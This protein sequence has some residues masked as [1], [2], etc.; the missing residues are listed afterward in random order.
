[1]GWKHSHNRHSSLYIY[2]YQSLGHLLDT[3]AS[4]AGVTT[5]ALA[6]ATGVVTDTTARAVLSGHGTVATV[7]FAAIVVEDEIA[8]GVGFAHISL[9]TN[10]SRALSVSFLPAQCAEGSIVLQLVVGDNDSAALIIERILCRGAL[11]HGAT[12]TTVASI[13]QTTVVHARVPGIVVRSEVRLA[14]HFGDVGSVSKDLRGFGNGP[15]IGKVLVGAAGAVSGAVIRAGST[16]ARRAGVAREAGADSSG[17]IAQT[18]VTAFA[19]R[20]VVA[21]QVRVGAWKSS[22]FAES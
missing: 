11:N 10:C 21:G 6:C 17:A 2:E 4:S 7:H 18:L 19:F 1:M 12:R 22:S 15:V 3:L 5:E 20:L 9:L 13:A 8:V 16:L 14:E